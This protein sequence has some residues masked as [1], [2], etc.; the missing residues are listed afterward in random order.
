MPGGCDCFLA[1][2]AKVWWTPE[3][4]GVVFCVRSSTGGEC[5]S[6]GGLWGPSRLFGSSPVVVEARSDFW[7]ENL[8]VKYISYLVTF[9][10]LSGC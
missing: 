2:C 5:V 1:G 9:S 10:V 6:G 7:A 3:V 4:K 8:K